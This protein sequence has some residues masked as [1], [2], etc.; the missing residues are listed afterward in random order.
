MAKHLA[1]HLISSYRRGIDILFLYRVPDK[2]QMNG[3]YIN[4]QFECGTASVGQTVNKL[5]SI[6]HR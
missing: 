5:L 3:T 4:L 1:G 2:L 6:K